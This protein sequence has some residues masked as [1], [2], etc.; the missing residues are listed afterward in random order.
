MNPETNSTRPKWY[1]M[2]RWQWT[3]PGR[4]YYGVLLAGA[5]SSL[6]LLAIAVRHEWIQ[7]CWDTISTTGSAIFL[8]GCLIGGFF[9]GPRDKD[10][11]KKDE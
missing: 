9:E 1:Q 6:I 8:I 11:D 5:G 7:P 10:N 4:Y 3:G 2:P